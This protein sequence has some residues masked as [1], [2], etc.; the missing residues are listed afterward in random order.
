MVLVYGFLGSYCRD[1]SRIIFDELRVEDLI[2][3]W[4]F[5]MDIELKIISF[6]FY[7]LI[8]RVIWMFFCYGRFF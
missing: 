7:G 5:S 1:L 8:Y 3:R 2:I 4:F 6:L